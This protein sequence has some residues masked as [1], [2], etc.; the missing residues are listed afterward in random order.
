[1]VA[2]KH[3]GGITPPGKFGIGAM[4]STLGGAGPTLLY[5]ARGTL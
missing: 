4:A 5:F 3:R 2:Y 1:M